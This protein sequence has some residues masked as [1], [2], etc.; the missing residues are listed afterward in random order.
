[1]LAFMPF[2][3]V[4]CHSDRSEMCQEKVWYLDADSDGLG[5]PDIIEIQCSQPNG[6]VRNKDDEDDI[7]SN[8]TGDDTTLEIN[9]GVQ[10]TF[11]LGE[12]KASYG[13]YLYTPSEYHEGDEERYPLLIHLHGGGARG[14]SLNKSQR[15]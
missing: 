12:T 4:A 7:R 8:T 10:Q 2:I 15:S 9:P 3:S 6:Y 11:L 1:M 14:N 13:F 5:D